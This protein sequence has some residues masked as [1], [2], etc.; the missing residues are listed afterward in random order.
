MTPYRV[1]VWAPRVADGGVEEIRF[2]GTYAE[3]DDE[4]LRLVAD[5]MPPDWRVDQVA[6]MLS[7]AEVD[8]LC[9]SP[10][11]VRELS[12]FAIEDMLRPDQVGLDA[13]SSDFRPHYPSPHDAGSSE[14]PK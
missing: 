3:C 14:H 9:L 2:F 12:S 1:G 13:E 10:G 8:S 11:E 7:R 4:A 6:G 5:G